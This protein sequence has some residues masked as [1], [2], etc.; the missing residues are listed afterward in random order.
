MT[1]RR[2]IE[3]FCFLFLVTNGQVVTV[4][5]ESETSYVGDHTALSCSYAILDSSYL[6]FTVDWFK[7]ES[8]SDPSTLKIAEFY[9]D[10]T[11]PTYGSAHNDQSQYNVSRSGNSGSFISTFEIFNVEFSRDRGRYLCRVTV[12][13]SDGMNSVNAVATT[14]LIVYSKYYYFRTLLK[15][16]EHYRIVFFCQQ[17][18]CWQ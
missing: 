9:L 18:S 2:R 5:L 11:S 10:A 4:S 13:Q 17:N 3:V 12:V 14:V 15:I 8:V 1:F 6:V 7:G 16:K